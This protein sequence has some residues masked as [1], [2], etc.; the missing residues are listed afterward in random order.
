[1]N[2]LLRLSET[3]HPV[4]LNAYR[5]KITKGKLITKR[6]IRIDTELEGVRVGDTVYI[7]VGDVISYIT[8]AEWDQY[9]KE[10]HVIE[11]S[12]NKMVTCNIR[13]RTLF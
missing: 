10:Q 5:W 11:D 6:L 4:T 9:Q 12:N 13:H 7:H 1:M 3:I 2:H 8:A